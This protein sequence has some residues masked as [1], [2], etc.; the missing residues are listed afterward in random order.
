[1]LFNSIEFAFFLPIVFILYWLINGKNLKIQN[2]LLVLASYL[3]YGWWD[4]RFLSLIIFSSSVDYVIGLLLVRNENVS[5]RKLLL[6]TSIVINLGFLGFLSLVVGF[7]TWWTSS[8]LIERL[9]HK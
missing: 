3:F 6:S 1:M 5:K 7:I 4:W 2:I 8:M 9:A